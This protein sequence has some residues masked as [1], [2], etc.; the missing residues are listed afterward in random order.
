MLHNKLSVVSILGLFVLE[1]MTSNQAL[2][3]NIDMQ[4]GIITNSV[5]WGNALDAP[6]KGSKGATSGKIGKII[7]MKKQEIE[8]RD[9]F[10]RRC[11]DGEARPCVMIA[12][13]IYEWRDAEEYY[14]HA[15]KH[16]SNDPLLIGSVAYQWIER[17]E[18][19]DEAVILLAKAV[20]LEFEKPEFL[21]SW[22]YR[23]ERP[24]SNEELMARIRQ[25]VMDYRDNA[26]TSN[27]LSM[28][29]ALRSESLAYAFFNEKHSI[30]AAYIAS[31]L[32]LNSLATA[33]SFGLEDMTHTFSAGCA[34]GDAVSCIMIGKATYVWDE[35]EKYFQKALEY[36]PDDP[37]VMGSVAYRWIERKE[38]IHEAMNLL[39]RAVDLGLKNPD[40]LESLKGQNDDP[41]S[42]KKLKYAH[43]QSS[44]GLQK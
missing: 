7:K 9:K 8:A 25:A 18:S 35:A 26:P 19:L 15:L 1:G 33:L 29:L 17:K 11:K 2:A 12:K 34:D 20:E 23:Y 10:E 13:T 16:A 28:S 5:I 43:I 6:V 30:S 44:Y 3:Q 27:T 4:P 42:K 40:F 36:A 38:N 21:A 37:L 32:W 39:E 31:N 41:D 14:R 22:I 24:S